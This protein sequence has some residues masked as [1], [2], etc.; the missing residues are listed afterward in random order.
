MTNVH[1]TGTEVCRSFVTGAADKAPTT[2]A[3]RVLV[4]T[5]LFFALIFLTLYTGGV[6][7]FLMT[8]SL[9]TKVTRFQDFWDKSAGPR[10][11]AKNT[12]CVPK[13]SASV[14]SFLA[15]QLPLLTA[16]TEQTK[17]NVI[18]LYICIY[19]LCRLCPCQ[20]ASRDHS[21][22]AGAKTVRPL[23]HV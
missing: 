20:F 6:A 3:G 14:S 22:F 11:N 1:A 15:V 8:D 12:I 13:T 23:T 16:N 17:W 18:P 7:T 4:T 5:Q 21:Q 10:Y 2:L 19:I 9:A